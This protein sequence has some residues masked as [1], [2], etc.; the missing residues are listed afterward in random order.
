MDDVYMLRQEDLIENPTARVPIS[1]VLDVS[2]SM[3]GDPISEL[4]SGVRLF[5]DAIRDDE[6]AQYAAEISIVTFGGGVQQVLDFMS[7]EH[8][9]LPAL[10]ATGRTPMGEALGVG[11]DLL[12]ARKAD[13]KRAGVDYYQP[14]LVVMTDG[15]PTD[16]IRPAA[17]RIGELVAAKKLSVFAIGIGAQA[18]MNR[19][20]EVAG[21]R[22]PLRLQG[23]RFNAFFEWL[24]QSVS[25]VS[26]STPGDKVELDL[27]GIAD[28]GQV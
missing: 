28:W 17:E 24:S 26:Q 4:N 25:R 15:V 12:E 9:D 8:Q 27:A 16:D 3:A 18:D 11:L 5:F 21:G 20:Q 23:L 19:L 6:V 2:G 10:Q 7:I 1:L 22:Q 13:Y 14:W